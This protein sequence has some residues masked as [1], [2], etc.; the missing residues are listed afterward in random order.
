MRNWWWLGV[1]GGVKVRADRVVAKGIVVD[2][3]GGG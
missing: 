3:R 2:G 1:T